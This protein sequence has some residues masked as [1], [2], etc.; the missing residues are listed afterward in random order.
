[1]RIKE[2]NLSTAQNLPPSGMSYVCVVNKTFTF[3]LILQLYCL[4][5]IIYI[6]LVPEYDVT[7]PFKADEE[8]SFLTYSLNHRSKRSLPVDDD[9]NATTY[10]YIMDV[11]GEQLHLQVK[12]N[13]KFMAPDLQM[14]THDK[15]GR[16]ITKAVSRK[17]FVTGKVAS[18]SDSVVALSVTD[19]LVRTI[20]SFS[21]TY[22]SHKKR[23]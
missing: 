3:N 15:E 17:A 14:E 7:S 1:M 10:H 16:Q 18:D 5:Y 9:D 23:H 11:S 21:I 13:T 2:L 6:F 19:R 20:F 12:R 8:G 4:S 22:F